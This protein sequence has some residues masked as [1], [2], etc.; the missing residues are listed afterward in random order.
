[1]PTESMNAEPG[2]TNPRRP[3][4]RHAEA[5]HAERRPTELAHDER[6]RAGPGD[7]EL[8]SEPPLVLVTGATAGIGHAAARRLADLGWSVLV[9]GRTVETAEEACT[10]LREEI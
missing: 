7:T 4:R 2:R 10:R 9:H 1:M 8:S 5:V 3:D 6:R